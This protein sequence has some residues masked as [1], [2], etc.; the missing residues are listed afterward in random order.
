MKELQESLEKIPITSKRQA[1]L[2]RIVLDIFHVLA[3]CNP[4]PCQEFNLKADAREMIDEMKAESE[5]R[6]NEY[7]EKRDKEYERLVKERNKQ[8]NES[9]RR[10]EEKYDKVREEMLNH[11]F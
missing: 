11:L 4:N 6:L 5:G 3:N 8:L 10:E 1:Y 9:K 2:K 7:L